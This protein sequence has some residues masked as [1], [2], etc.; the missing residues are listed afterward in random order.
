MGLKAPDDLRLRLTLTTDFG[1]ADGY[2]GAL[3]GRILSMAPHAVIHDISH[4]IAPQAVA[5]GA[6]CLRRAAPRFPKGTIHLAVVDPGVGSPRAGL[7]IETERFLLLG[8]DNGLLSLAAREGG[9]SRIFALEESPPE[10]VRSETFD[11]LT[12][13]APAAA[14]LL[15]GGRPEDLGSR[16]AESEIETI[17][18]KAPQPGEAMVTGEIIFFDRFGNAITNIT[19]AGLE[20]REP[21]RVLLDG[22]EEADFCGHYANLAG[23]PGRPGAL[24][25]SDGNLELA[26]YSDSISQKLK[27][28]E[29][30]KVK[31]ELKN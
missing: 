4:E 15:L 27:L 23:E 22:R 9:E 13:F 20:G 25:N 19:R 11:G 31:L 16:I 6:R 26:L 5:Q 18:I 2:A 12:F 24:W 21:E 10:R 14:R 29:G 17:S 30:D 3:K 28:R 8:P 7:I 1:T